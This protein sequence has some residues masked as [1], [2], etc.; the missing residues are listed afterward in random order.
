MRS[1][2]VPVLGP[3]LPLQRLMTLGGG[4]LHQFALRHRGPRPHID[5]PTPAPRVS[6]LIGSWLGPTSLQDPRGHPCPDCPR[7]GQLR[8]AT[9]VGRTT[10]AAWATPDRPSAT[11]IT[12]VAVATGQIL[13][14]LRAEA[15]PAAWPL[16]QTGPFGSVV[17][18]G[19]NPHNVCWAPS[20]C[21]RCGAHR[22]AAI[23]T[24][25]LRPGTV[26]HGLP[27]PGVAST[28][29]HTAAFQ[30]SFDG[31][32]R[33]AFGDVAL[34]RRAGGAG[35]AL[36]GPIRPSGSRAC[37]AQA[38]LSVPGCD[39]SVVAEA[40]GLRLAVALARA[41]GLPPSS[42]LVMGDNLGVVRTGAGFGRTRA[43]PV[44]CVLETPVMFLASHGW[45]PDWA[46]V[47][48]QFNRMADRLATR[49]T[50]TSVLAACSG[51]PAGLWVWAAL[52]TSFSMIPFT[53]WFPS[54]HSYR[55]TA[56]LWPLP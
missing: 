53:E 46:A 24:S 50:N 49:A 23:A 1:L 26:L 28:S 31:G 22:L 40:L 41:A 25:P 32:A 15:A 55:E 3:K 13:F 5:G 4:I 6:D 18:E 27:A 7:V 51:L 14:E 56:P 36:W 29:P 37:I 21:R 19:V 42:L 11:L 30:V 10:A 47:R 16:D 52:N 38:S 33:L 20:R 43:D 45:T 35:A 34:Q 54:A 12:S 39:N 8:V 44:W 9:S 2:S 48:R 17:T